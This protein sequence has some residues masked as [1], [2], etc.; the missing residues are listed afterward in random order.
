MRIVYK[1]FFCIYIYMPGIVLGFSEINNSFLI[2]LYKKINFELGEDL[3]ELD[4][5]P[6]ISLMRIQ[7]NFNDSII[8]SIEND[9]NSKNINNIKI[10]IKSVG[11]FKKDKDKFVLFLTP[12]YNKN[13]KNIHKEVWNLFNKK[14]DLLQEK[15]YSPKSYSPHLTIPI[16]NPTKKNVSVVLN[17][18]LDID[19]QISL[20]TKSIMFINTSKETDKTIIHINKILNN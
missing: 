9:L 7:K 6:H 13:F 5:I 1:F 3:I 19:L 18:L 10:N 14:L 16:K 2:D 11:I 4:K 12:D 17:K 15:Y 8:K 20:N